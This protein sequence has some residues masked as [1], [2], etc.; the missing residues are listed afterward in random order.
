MDAEI[1]VSELVANAVEHGRG[2]VT[3]DVEQEV[4]RLRVEVASAA[5]TSTPRVLHPVPLEP[6]GRGL[7]IVDALA[8][9]WGHRDDRGGR[10]TVWAELDRPE[11]APTS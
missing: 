6:S 5:G 3:V 7:L 1:V 8:S 10:R 9:T 2:L 4:H 11:S